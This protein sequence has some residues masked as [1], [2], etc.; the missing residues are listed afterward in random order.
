MLCEGVNGWRVEDLG[1]G[2]GIEPGYGGGE[3]DDLV[4][5]IF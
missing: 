4:W 5:R 2:L 3:G 1:L